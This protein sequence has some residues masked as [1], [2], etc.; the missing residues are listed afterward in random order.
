MAQHSSNYKISNGVK[1]PHIRFS[2]AYQAMQ[3]V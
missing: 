2:H 3:T 1:K